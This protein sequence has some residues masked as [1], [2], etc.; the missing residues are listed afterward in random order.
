MC[1][2]PINGILNYQL[3]E[4]GE[5]FLCNIFRPSVKT[6]LKIINKFTHV[7]SMAD[8]LSY[9]AITIT[10]KQLIQLKMCQNQFRLESGNC[11]KLGC[12]QMA[13][14]LHR[15]LNIYSRLITPLK[16]N[17][18]CQS[19]KKEDYLKRSKCVL[20]FMSCQVEKGLFSKLK[21]SSVVPFNCVYQRHYL[22]R[23]C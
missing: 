2:V 10:H 3:L 20:P 6:T 9:T 17:I 5:I 4:T 13:L 19:R 21:C 23:V 7:L 22:H 8:S 18:Q 1:V 14:L 15:E 16:L 11:R 12:C